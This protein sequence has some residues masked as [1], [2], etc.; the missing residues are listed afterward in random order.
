MKKNVLI[1][2]IVF[3]VIGLV[4]IVVGLYLYNIAQ[5]NYHAAL[6]YQKMGMT[7]Y[8]PSDFQ[9]LMGFW[10]MLVVFGIFLFI[11]GIPVTIIG[12]VIGKE[13]TYNR[14][15]VIDATSNTTQK[16]ESE[17]EVLKIIQLRYAKG[18]ITKEQFEQMKKDLV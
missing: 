2:G 10:N 3:I 1:A 9:G 18:E 5:Q 17:N 14:V 15:N 13:V 4:M 7:Q 16:T 12:A 8:N 6:L 11:T